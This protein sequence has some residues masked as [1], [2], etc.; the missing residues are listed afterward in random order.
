VRHA[1]DLS[2]TIVHLTGDSLA[3]RHGGGLPLMF[4]HAG[5]GYRDGDE[6]AQRCQEPTVT[7]IERMIIDSTQS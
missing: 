4:L 5:I 7:V 3:F 1:E 2:H 6:F